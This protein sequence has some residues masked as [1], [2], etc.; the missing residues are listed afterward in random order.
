MI[1]LGLCPKTNLCLYSVRH[2]NLGAT[3]KTPLARAFLNMVMTFILHP[4]SHY[5]S[6]TEPC[7]WFLLSLLEGLTINLPSHFITSLIDIYKDT[8]PHDKL[9]FPLA[10]TWILWHSSVS[11]P[12]SPYFFVMCAID[13]STI[14][15]CE[16][17]LWPKWPQTEMATLPASSALSASAPSSFAGEVTLEAIMA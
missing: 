8:T 3:V 10:I 13:A 6:I 2:T 15:Q 16:A 14:R 4:L 1:V 17:Q 7:V 12:E 5:N 9:I 11:Y